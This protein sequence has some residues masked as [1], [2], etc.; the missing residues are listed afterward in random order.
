MI[1]SIMK[2]PRRYEIISLNN[3]TEEI[4]VTEGTSS[5]EGGF[6]LRY[7]E[8]VQYDLY[9]LWKRISVQLPFFDF[10]INISF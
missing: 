7:I 3:R 4:V 5:R 6:L 10:Y 8:E 2:D 1:Y 9:S